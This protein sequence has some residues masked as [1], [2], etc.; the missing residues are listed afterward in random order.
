MS[1][2]GHSFQIYVTFHLY[3]QFKLQLKFEFFMKR[4]SLTLVIHIQ[5]IYRLLDFSFITLIF[6]RNDLIGST[7]KIHQIML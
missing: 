4:P 2:L 3:I 7:T 5:S 6:A 1:Y